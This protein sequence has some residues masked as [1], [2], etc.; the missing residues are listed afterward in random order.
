MGVDCG[1]SH[2]CPWPIVSGRANGLVEA[3]GCGGGIGWTLV[4]VVDVAVS[5]WPGVEVLGGVMTT[6]GC[7]PAARAAGAEGC[8]SSTSTLSRCSASWQGVVSAVG[9]VGGGF[10]VTL[11]VFTCARSC[12]MSIA[13]LGG[14]CVFP[15]TSFVGSGV[16]LGQA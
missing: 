14:L 13:E 9:G 4:G 2:G 10:S 12:A 15:R 11:S 1:L 6:G 16:W 5:V 7:G 3:M 8:S